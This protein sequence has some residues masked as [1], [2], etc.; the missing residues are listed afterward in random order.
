MLIQDK[1][2]LACKVEDI[3][4]SVKERE[5]IHEKLMA[6]QAEKFKREFKK[7][8]EAWF[9]SEKVRRERWEADKIKEI[10]EGTVQKLEPTI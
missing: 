10:R 5:L 4:K 3:S 2:R 8:R 1:E 7:E 9:A 6:E